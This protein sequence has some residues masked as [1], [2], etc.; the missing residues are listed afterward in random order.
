MLFSVAEIFES[1]FS[2]NQNPQNS[3]I[4][5]KMV[6]QQD[7]EQQGD[8]CFKEAGAAHFHIPYM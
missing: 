6:L 3:G 2:S 7:P 5:T 8:L 1:V 4:L